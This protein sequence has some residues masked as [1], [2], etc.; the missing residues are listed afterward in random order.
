MNDYATTL[1]RST[2]PKPGPLPK[3]SFPAFE[4][5]SLSNGLD[6]WTVQNH[7]QPIISLSLYIRGGSACDPR[8]REGLAS[9]VAELLTKGTVRRTATQIAEEID[10]VGGSLSASS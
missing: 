7:E 1:D 10:F 3:V 2:A 5:G 9:A 8:H 6:I 4:V